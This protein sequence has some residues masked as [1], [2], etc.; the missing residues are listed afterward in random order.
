M[1]LKVPSDLIKNTLRKSWNATQPLPQ[2]PSG[3][4]ATLARDK[5]S[6]PEWSLKF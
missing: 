4:I 3:Q 5:Y 2:V 1:N 6:Q